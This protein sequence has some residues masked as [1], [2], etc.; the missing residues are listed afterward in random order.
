[1][2]LDQFRFKGA[3]RYG[4]KNNPT[5]RK[6]ALVA[7]ELLLK[8]LRKLDFQLKSWPFLI[9]LL[10]LFLCKTNKSLYF[11][12]P[13]RTYSHMCISAWFI[14]IKDTGCS[15]RTMLVY[16]VFIDSGYIFISTS[17]LK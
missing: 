2:N 17:A 15:C 12:S 4:L 5:V 7:D 9:W 6:V 1:M 14:G 10:S 8:G 13:K 11:N 3:C 16:S